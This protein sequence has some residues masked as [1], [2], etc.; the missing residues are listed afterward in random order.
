LLFQA[1][2]VPENNQ[3]NP[4]REPV[5]SKARSQRDASQAG[6]AHFDHVRFAGEEEEYKEIMPLGGVK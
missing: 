3:R 5:S 1:S 2:C 6:S 4:S